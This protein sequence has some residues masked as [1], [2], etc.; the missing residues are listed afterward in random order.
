MSLVKEHVARK[1]SR[2]GCCVISRSNPSSPIGVF[3][4]NEYEIKG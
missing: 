3:L 4:L 2:L 1:D